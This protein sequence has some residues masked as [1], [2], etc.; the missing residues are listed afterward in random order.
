MT[1]GDVCHCKGKE[2]VV[3][4]GHPIVFPSAGSHQ[5]T[6]SATE[7]AAV[8]EDSDSRTRTLGRIIMSTSMLSNGVYTHLVV[9]D[10]VTV[11]ADFFQVPPKSNGV[12][13]ASIVTAPTDILKRGRPSRLSL[14]NR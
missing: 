5:T 14:V 4:R 2:D 8:I 12:Q 13:S 11:G 1:A 3:D 7:W 10:T 9:L 6:Y